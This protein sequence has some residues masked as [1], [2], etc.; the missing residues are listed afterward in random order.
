MID[1]QSF[2]EGEERRGERKEVGEGSGGS[3]GNV[4]DEV[5]RVEV[6]GVE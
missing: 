6:R 3:E 2:V 5:E 1:D 4:V